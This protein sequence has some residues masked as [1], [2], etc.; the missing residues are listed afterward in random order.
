MSF[1]F[2]AINLGCN[3]NLVDLEVVIG[4]ILSHQENHD[5]V[6]FENPDDEEVE[7]LL[8]NTC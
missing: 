2:S 4:K 5:I 8:I 3:K 7:Y 1:Y 6:F